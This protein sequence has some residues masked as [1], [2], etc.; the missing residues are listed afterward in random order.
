MSP[1][2]TRLI[3]LI[4]KIPFRFVALLAVLT[5]FWACY[6]DAETSYSNPPQSGTNQWLIE[7]KTGEANVQL[8]MRYTRQRGDGGLG[9]SNSGFQLPMDQL[10]GLTR[11]QAMSMG[12]HVQFQLKRDAGTFNFE[13]WFKEGNGSGHFTFNPNASFASELSRQGLGKATDE[14]ML[15]LA[16]G[17]VG[18]TFI[19]ELRSQGY[20]DLATV[21]QLVKM[22]HHGVRL[23]YIQGLKAMGYSLK[24]VELLVK[25]KDHGVSLNFI[26]EMNGLGYNGLSAEE[27]IRTKDHGVNGEFIQG[28][29][30]AGY[31]RANLDEW[32][33]LKDHGVNLSFVTALKDLGYSR[34]E[35]EQLRTMKDHGVSSSF[36]QE[37]KAIGYTNI[38]VDQLIRLKDHGVNANYIQRLKE[39]GY[40]ELTLDEY[41]RLKD[42]G[43]K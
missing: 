42:R 21:D 18:S 24:S 12:S 43:T 35:L 36:I 23:E 11:E 16:I 33:T 15:S 30:A 38:P 41:I 13:G 37:L 32:I 34:L 39:R 3:T 6:P 22:A 40:G 29:V 9:F 20:E 7:I 25:M 1:M 4:A 31:S 14:Q 26:R 8:T 10:V 28:F 27:L 17:D 5:L 19:S 2:F